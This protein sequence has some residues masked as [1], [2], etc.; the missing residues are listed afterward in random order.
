MLQRILANI[1]R[2]GDIEIWVAQS[3]LGEVTFTNLT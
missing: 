1:D 3:S 2:A